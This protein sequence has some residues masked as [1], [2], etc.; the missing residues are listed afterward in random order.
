MFNFTMNLFSFRFGVVLWKIH[1]SKK[2]ET[3][4]I[5]KTFEIKT[6]VVNFQII[7]T[8]AEI[9]FSVSECFPI[10]PWHVKGGWSSEIAFKVD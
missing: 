1:T 3:R 5:K 8:K 4:N 10:K 7:G 6:Q 2:Q 9:F